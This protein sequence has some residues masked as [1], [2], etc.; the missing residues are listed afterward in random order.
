M[1][2][3]WV[4]AGQEPEVAA[5][6]RHKMTAA[7]FPINDPLANLR[8]HLTMTTN[9]GLTCG[10]YV[11]WNW[12]PA[13][14]GAELAEEVHERVVLIVPTGRVKVQFDIEAHDP[15]YILDCLRRWRLIRPKQDT[16]WTLESFQG[17]WMTPEFVAEIV[18]LKVRVVPQYYG[19]DMTPFAADM[20]LRD[21]T[22]RGFPE[23]LVTGFYDAAALPYRW[24]GYCL[25]Q[26][27]LP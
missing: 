11:A 13:L 24:D 3:C 15:D 19:G 20:A 18:A 2:A 5:L 12:Y 7:F 21:L 10:L 14:T 16:S 26:G 27:R 23:A 9:A 22:R 17:G 1:R 8:A 25:S 6:I 4:D